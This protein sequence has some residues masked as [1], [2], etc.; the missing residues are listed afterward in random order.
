MAG[1]VAAV[2]TGDKDAFFAALTDEATV[3]DDGTERPL[4]AWA[5]NGTFSSNG[6]LDAEDTSADGR[7]L[8]AT[9]TNSTWGSMRTR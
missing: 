5:D 9:H 3:S 4:A 7:A 2:D 8:T 6:R 1:F